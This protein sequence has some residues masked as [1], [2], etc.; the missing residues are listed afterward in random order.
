MTTST[1]TSFQLGRATFAAGALFFVVCHSGTPSFGDAPA[2]QN[3]AS[4]GISTLAGPA[5]VVDGDTIDINGQRIR[6]E[7]IDAPET[8][9]TCSTARGTAWA[10]GRAATKTLAALVA[11]AD[12]ACDSRGADKYGR[13]LGICYANGRDIN[14]AMVQAGMAWAFIKYSTTY[15]SEEGAARLAN[16]GI[17]QGPSEA[18]W[19]FRHKGWQ[20]AE[21]VAP[22]GCA[23]KGN[24]SSKG[25]IYHMPWSPWYERVTV[26]AARGE[27]WFCSESEA[28][29][30]GWRP[31][32]TN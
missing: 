24:V 17:W 5:Q 4:D 11:G 25:H 26:D 8:A 29:A 9:Q 2:V 13:L 15:V 1:P 32:L 20:V 18:P 30:A 22:N 28:Q 10:C 3:A 21:A 16:A 12:V 19:D 6:L 23:I 27:Q 7:G 14:A 31:A